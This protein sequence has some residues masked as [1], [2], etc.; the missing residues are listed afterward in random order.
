MQPVKALARWILREEIQDYVDA[1]VKGE[2]ELKQFVDQVL[3]DHTP[4]FGF[5]G[6]ET[7]TKDKTLKTT[8]VPSPV[9][10]SSGCSRGQGRG[11][12]S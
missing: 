3:D 10:K 9:S 11:E 7:T 4:N 6:S 2:R 8:E 1:I 12:V 5:P